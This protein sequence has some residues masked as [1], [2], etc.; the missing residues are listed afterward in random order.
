[1]SV[2]EL[3]KLILEM[4]QDV[5]QR[6]CRDS[7]CLDMLHFEDGFSKNVTCGLHQI[8]SCFF[9]AWSEL[10]RIWC[11]TTMFQWT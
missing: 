8:T 6:A 2:T 11:R 5:I 7:D 10:N 1:M 9:Q 4:D 3:V